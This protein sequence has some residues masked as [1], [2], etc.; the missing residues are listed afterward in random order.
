MVCLLGL[1]LMSFYNMGRVSG[2]TEVYLKLHREKTL[3]LKAM[4]KL[5]Q[6]A[7]LR[8]ETLNN[9]SQEELTHRLNEQIKL[10]ENSND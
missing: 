2:R 3:L 5:E 6:L 4:A 8:G 1:A 9:L 7:Q 10:L